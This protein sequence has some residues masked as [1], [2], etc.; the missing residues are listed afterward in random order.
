MVI[1]ALS[2]NRLNAN[3]FVEM[4]ICKFLYIYLKNIL[5]LDYTTTLFFGHSINFKV[6]FSLL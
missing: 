3:I 2:V 5:Y 6:T 1:G 4:H